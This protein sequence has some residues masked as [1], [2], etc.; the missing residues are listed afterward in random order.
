MSDQER[1]VEL[2]QRYFQAWF[3]FH[4]ELAVDV[5]AA[6][7]ADLLPP[8]DDD[9]MRALLALNE[10]VLSTLEEIKLDQLTPAAQLDYQLLYGS[11]MIEGHEMLAMDWRLNSPQRFLPVQAIYQLTVKPVADPALC[12]LRRLEAVPGQ[13]R[14][15]RG[16][17][18]REPERIPAVWLEAAVQEAASGV[19]YLQFLKLQPPFAA[20]TPAM[21][22]ALD[23]AAA[24]LGGFARF[25]ERELAPRAQGDF[26]VGEARFSRYLQH[27][28]FLDLSPAQ[29]LEFG[30]RLFSR[31]AEELAQVTQQLRGDLDVEALTRQLQQQHPAPQALLENYR[32]AM[33][34][35]REFVRERDLVSFPAVEHLD[36]VA[37]PGF[38]QHQI[39][40]AAYV[41]PAA[42]DARQQGYY[43][44][45]PVDDAAGMGEHNAQAIRHTS[46]HESYPGHHLQFVTANLN[47]EA[48]SL[49]RL[50]SPSAT[51]YEGWALYCEQLMQEQGFLGAPENRF[52]LLKD[53]LW[54]ALRIIIDVEI[55]TRG[56]SLRAASER[57]QQ[58]L[59]FTAAQADA[60]LSWYSM[61][62]TVPLGY[63][64]GWAL[65]NAT[66]DCLRL[67]QPQLSL[68]DFHDAL[69]AEG[70]VALPAVISK[71]FGHGTWRDVRQMVFGKAH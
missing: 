60:D 66:R 16:Y 10:K 54:R 43:Y 29:L 58:L 37:T 14:K 19:D 30:Q 53:R 11:A 70:S 18:G 42:G 22:L 6:G 55:Q 2:Q 69:L 40:F 4:P 63:G 59:G 56:M 61:A 7:Y 26:A 21:G 28:H 17:L 3:R 64:V 8:L 31:T 27:R 25:L 52:L 49:A 13:L 50:T 15:A 20:L 35:A 33:L 38:L 46:V 12:M 9:D 34:A 41:A 45:T 1:F 68:R 62:P 57:M 39:P 65:I 71:R 24:A 32:Q 48:S 5:G 67:Q 23:E 44:V 51:L 47:P 36:V